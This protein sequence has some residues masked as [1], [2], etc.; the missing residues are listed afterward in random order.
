MIQDRSLATSND[1][2]KHLTTKIST[3]VLATPCAPTL[4]E[5]RTPS[6]PCEAV[7]PCTQSRE[8][9]CDKMDRNPLEDGSVSGQNLA[10]GPSVN[11]DKFIDFRENY[12]PEVVDSPVKVADVYNKL[13]S[14]LDQLTVHD[15]RHLLEDA[16]VIRDSILRYD[17]PSVD[18]LKNH[19]RRQAAKNLPVWLQHNRYFSRDRHGEESIMPALVPLWGVLKDVILT[20]SVYG[21]RPKIACNSQSLYDRLVIAFIH[22][23]I[24]AH[25][26]D[27]NWIKVAKYKLAAFAS[28]AKG[29]NVY[30]V[31]PFGELD[32]PAI[33]FDKGLKIYTDLTMGRKALSGRLF[34]MSL[35]DSICRGI[36][37]GAARPSKLD[38]HNSCL[39][40]VKLFTK[41]DKPKL[42]YTIPN[43]RENRDLLYALY[44]EHAYELGDQVFGTE[45]V[46]F[47][48]RRSIKELLRDAGEFKP[49]Y[50]HVPSFS[51]GTEAPLKNGGQCKV[52]KESVGYKDHPLFRIKVKEGF[53]DGSTVKAVKPVTED[54]D[55]SLRPQDV[56]FEETL[57]PSRCKYVEIDTCDNLR[58]TDDDEVE[59]LIVECLNEDSVIHPIGLAEALKVRGITTPN[60]LET[61]LLKPLQKYLAQALLKFKCFT[62]TGQPLKAEHLNDIFSGTTELDGPFVSGDYDNATNEMNSCYTR[63]AIRFICECLELSPLYT[64][65]AE[66][67]LVDNIITYTWIPEGEV[68]LDAELTQTIGGKQLEAQPMGKIL[69][70]VVLC[71]INFSMCRKALEIDQGKVISMGNFPGLIN[72]DDCCFRIKKFETWVGMTACVGLFNSIGKT[73]YST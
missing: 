12:N 1:V 21:Y 60:P 68:S 63:T 2:Q 57:K 3:E 37:K 13:R 29:S 69:S 64:R 45:D 30:P 28:Y 48:I 67:S 56:S 54:K 8:E 5:E 23:C 10:L 72:G 58:S 6:Y 11:I 49:T 47:E 50:S 24:L 27:Y 15:P 38:C 73:F 20:A 44:P 4:N 65:L 36:K 46:D 14:Y 51:S 33:I 59:N 16:E 34:H 43:E 26:V 22:W 18:T 61:W 55:Q 71:I 52:V 62:V 70:F 41:A 32:N 53:F 17:L 25:H 19:L 35:V 40:T 42:T 7:K 9:T 39:A 66:R 31:S